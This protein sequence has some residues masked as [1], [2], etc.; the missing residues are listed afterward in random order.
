MAKKTRMGLVT[1]EWV[2]VGSCPTCGAP[3]WNDAKSVVQPP[4]TRFSCACY[5]KSRLEYAASKGRP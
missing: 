1:T 4:P 2:K 5:P 3:I